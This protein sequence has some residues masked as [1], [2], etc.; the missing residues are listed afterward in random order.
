[1]KY[2]KWCLNAFH[3][4]GLGRPRPRGDVVAAVRL[5]GEDPAPVGVLRERGL[6]PL[7]ELDDV[8]A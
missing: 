7:N 3:I 1:M 8:Q 5:R 2:T 6:P 4:Q